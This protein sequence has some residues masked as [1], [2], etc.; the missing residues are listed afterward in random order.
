MSS[1]HK[2]LSVEHSCLICLF[3]M[4]LYVQSTIFQLYTVVCCTY[5]NAL[6]TIFIMETNTMNPDPSSS[7][8]LQYSDYPKN[9][10]RYE[11]YGKSRNW[12]ETK[13]CSLLLL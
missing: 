7:Y 5:L 9:K 3:D 11:A 4:I 2:S 13:I 6:Q 8:S 1:R 12:R 10:S